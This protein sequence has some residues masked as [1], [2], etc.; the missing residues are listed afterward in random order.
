MNLT[1]TSSPALALSHVWKK[2]Y[3]VPVLPALP[4]LPILLNNKIEGVGK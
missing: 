1:L 4:V 2:V 3:A